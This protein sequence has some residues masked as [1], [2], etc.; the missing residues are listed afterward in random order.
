VINL[1]PARDFLDDLTNVGTLV[2]IG[3]Q[4]GLAAVALL[5]GFYTARIVCREAATSSRRW[6]FGEGNFERV[7]FPLAAMGYT[8]LAELILGRYQSTALL[9]IQRSLLL[10][11][12]VIRVAVYVLRHIFPHGVAL[13]RA[14]RLIAWLAWISVALHV[15]GLLPEVIDALDSVGITVG[16][17]Q[18]RITLWIIVQAV[19]ALAITITLA[20]WV[21]RVTETRVLASQSVEMSTR[22]VIARVVRISALFVAVLVALPLVGLDVTT[23]SVFSGALGVGLGFGLQK[24]A[25]N[26]VSGFIV[27]LDR[28]LRIGDV[29]TVDGRKGEVKAI[30]TRYT[31]IK[32][33]D[34]VESII[35]N[36]FMI[37]QSVSHHTY[38][39]PKVAVVVTLTVA[40]ES[41][42]DLACDLLAE[43]AREHQ[44]VVAEPAAGA[45]VKNLAESGVELE[46][47]VWIADPSVGEGPLRS[48]LLKSIVRLFRQHG[49]SI[50]YPRRDVRLVATPEMRE[51]PLQSGG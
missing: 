25:S 31:V 48:D 50:P 34:G 27:L 33:L 46:L 2:E 10:A 41:D 19:G 38:S 51:N 43:A 20:L 23:L 17:N 7:A 16:K 42:L 11:L 18:Q 9:E 14:I 1:S 28:S 40:Y 12:L 15:T 6:K 39:D 29:V 3:W 4:V 26:Y 44:R 45:R 21:S 30:E 32:G 24:I 47:V 35:P 13:Q 8:A 36:E 5:L 49:I 37:T 22:I